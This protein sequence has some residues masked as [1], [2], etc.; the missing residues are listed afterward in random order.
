MS[1]SLR[2]N[3]ASTREAYRN[4][5]HESAD[6]SRFWLDWDVSQVLPATSTF[7]TKSL[8]SV[9]IFAF[10]IFTGIEK[11]FGVKDSYG[12][13]EAPPDDPGL[14]D[15]VQLGEATTNIDV[16]KEKLVGA[17]DT[18]KIVHA[19][20]S[21][22]AACRLDNLA[23]VLVNGGLGGIHRATWRYIE[24]NVKHNQSIQS[25]LSDFEDGTMAA[26]LPTEDMVMAVA[27]MVAVRRDSGLVPHLEELWGCLRQKLPWDGPPTKYIPV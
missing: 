21:E 25:S 13:D 7:A 16:A 3:S 4:L 15:F 2:D 24:K 12:I 23:A 17:K 22:T 18:I 8:Y 26:D 9:L 19:D 6:F 1:L 27:V 14:S 5:V 11:E 20:K 10:V